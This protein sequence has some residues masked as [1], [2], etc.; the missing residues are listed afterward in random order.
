MKRFFARS[1]LHN[2]SQCEDPS[3]PSKNLRFSSVAQDDSASILTFA[4][5]FNP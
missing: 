2:V 1:K 3:T 4:E 5:G